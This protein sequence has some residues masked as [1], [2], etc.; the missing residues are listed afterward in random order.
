MIKVGD[1]VYFHGTCGV[2]TYISKVGTSTI[3][4]IVTSSGGIERE[5]ITDV[6][7]EDYQ[8]YKTGLRFDLSE[9]LAQINKA[10]EDDMV[11]KML[12]RLAEE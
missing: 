3:Y 7:P 9:M 10:Y 1:I 12:A 6:T 2:V 5:V 4:D 8:L 11:K